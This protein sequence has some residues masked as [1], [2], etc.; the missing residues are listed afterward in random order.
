MKARADISRRQPPSNQQYL[1][2]PEGYHRP[3][4]MNMLK[5]GQGQIPK[6]RSVVASLVTGKMK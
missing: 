4:Q 2:Q 1:Q 3:M 6:P 5:I